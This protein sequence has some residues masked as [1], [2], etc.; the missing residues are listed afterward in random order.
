MLIEQV[1]ELSLKERFFY[2]I[3]ERT[4]IR[5]RRYSGEPK[6][7]TDDAILQSYRFCNVRRMDDKVSAWLY[8]NWYQ[9]NFDHK[10]ILAAVAI[11]RFINQVES[12]SYVGFPY[13]WDIEKI[14]SRM[15]KYRDDPASPTSIFSA[16]YMVRGGDAG[17]E[18]VS[19]VVDRYVNPLVVDNIKDQLDTEY[20]EES[21][22]IIQKCYGFG[23]F[24][25]GQIVADL[26]WAMKG[27][28][29]DKDTWAPVGPGSSRGMQRLLGI[30]VKASRQSRIVPQEEFMEFLTDLM[31]EGRKRK[32]LKKLPVVKIMEAQDWQNCLCEFDKYERVLW[33]Q[34]RPKQKY[35]G[36]NNE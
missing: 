3:K 6:P 31:E 18:K 5:T 2:W 24:N 33:N 13:K 11:A 20:M 9:P 30:D 34:G 17:G 21:H 28:W 36:V 7:W 19:D 35:D 29:V 25:A 8:N 14:K 1:A 4:A 22:A 27:D 23:S 15:R 26:R 12:L 32:D 10:N 16:A